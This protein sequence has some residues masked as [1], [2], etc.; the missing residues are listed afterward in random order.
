MTESH[1]QADT[2]I[3]IT[4]QMVAAAVAVLNDYDFGNMGPAFPDLFVTDII[5]DALA[6]RQIPSEHAR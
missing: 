3:E 6:S 4:P 5:T 2:K 1:R